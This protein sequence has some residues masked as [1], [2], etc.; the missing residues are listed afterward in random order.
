M[1]KLKASNLSKAYRLKAFG[2]L[3][4]GAYQASRVT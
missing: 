1:T 3:V 2:T 4:S